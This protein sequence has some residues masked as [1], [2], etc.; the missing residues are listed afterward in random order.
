MPDDPRAESDTEELPSAQ[1][2]FEM[3]GDARELSPGAVSRAAALLALVRPAQVSRSAFRAVTTDVQAELGVRS[4]EPR[5]DGGPLIEEAFGSLGTPGQRATSMLRALEKPAGAEEG[6]PG[7]GIPVERAPVESIRAYSAAEREIV[8]VEQAQAA[9][10]LF[11]LGEFAPESQRQSAAIRLVASSVLD[12]DRLVQV[13]AAGAMLRLDPRNRLAGALLDEASR[14][15]YYDDIAHLSRAILA[16]ARETET[17]RVEIEH[18]RGDVPPAPDSVLVHGTWARHGEWW[19]PNQDLHHYI[20]VEERL[21]PDLYTGPVAFRWSGY[22][23][24]RAWRRVKTDWDRQQA[25]ASL[26][27][28][29]ER[30][31]VAPPDLIGHSYGGSLALLATRV[32]KQVRGMILLSPAVHYSCLPDPTYYERILHVTT[33]LDLVLLADL[34]NP[35]LLDDFQ[36][37][38]KFTMKRKGL[39]G[40]AT[41]HDPQSWAESGLT[42]ELRDTW[43]PSLSARP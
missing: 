29:A 20:R 34:S 35:H 13:A 24:F 28:W 21:F 27:W 4:V 1:A 25:A 10:E 8:E 38:T 14:Y 15:S 42:D 2:A 39:L 32:E 12:A 19:Q 17:R 30:N 26:A 18:P 16:T 3:R 6:I 41:T 31:L 23:S 11:G 22:F 7:F 9:Q 5:D 43:L 37:V 33:K 36:G 40:H